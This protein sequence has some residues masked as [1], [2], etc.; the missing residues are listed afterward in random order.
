MYKK[1]N[2]TASNMQSYYRAKKM[3][4]Y[5]IEQVAPD[6]FLGC[7]LFVAGAKENKN[8]R[9]LVLKLM[10]KEIEEACDKF[11]IDSYREVPDD[12]SHEQ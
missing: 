12:N 7:F 3:I 6:D 10:P 8:I 2:I 4:K 1:I 9:P 11:V 5:I